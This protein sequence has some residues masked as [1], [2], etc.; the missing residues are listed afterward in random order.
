[1]GCVPIQWLN[2]VRSKFKA[3]FFHSF[4]NFKACLEVA[5]SWQTEEIANTILIKCT[6]HEASFIVHGQYLQK[7]GRHA[8]MK[9]H[10]DI[11]P[12]G[13]SRQKKQKLMTCPADIR[14]MQ[15]MSK[16]AWKLSCILKAAAKKGILSGHVIQV[17]QTVLRVRCFFFLVLN[18][19]KMT[20][21]QVTLCTP[22]TN[23]ELLSE[24]F[25]LV[26]TL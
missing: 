15:V 20:M 26:S 21:K 8:Y 1:M 16:Q 19:I 5:A 24:L 23:R 11:I 2:C 6:V 7:A 9:F 18:I 12:S 22:H 4:G 14:A 10:P 25:F 17:L 13:T 3:N